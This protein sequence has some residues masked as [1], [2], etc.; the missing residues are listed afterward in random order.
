ML[1][2]QISY[3]VAP[4]YFHAFKFDQFAISEWPPRPNRC[5]DSRVAASWWMGLII[6]VPVLLVGLMMPDAKAYL[7]RI[8]IAFAVVAAT[9]LV[10]GLGALAHASSS[11]TAFDLPDF[12]YPDG[13]TDRV[14]FRGRDHAQLQLPGRFPRRHHRFPVSR[15]R[16]NPSDEAIQRPRRAEQPIQMITLHVIRRSLRPKGDGNGAGLGLDSRAFAERATARFGPTTPAPRWKVLR[17]DD[18]FC[19]GHPGGQ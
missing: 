12:W 4:E 15:S 19:G 8:L 17:V 10:V 11:I 9:A 16:A 13:V 3:T 18:T 2:N 1:H 5:V 6:G 7:S 14:A